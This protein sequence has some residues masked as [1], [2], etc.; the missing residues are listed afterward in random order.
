LGELTALGGRVERLE[1]PASG[2]RA[3]EPFALV[4]RP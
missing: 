4:L 1:K 3:A 2:A